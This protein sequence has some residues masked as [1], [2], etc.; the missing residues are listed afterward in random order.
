MVKLTEFFDTY[1]LRARLRPALLTLFPALA[2]AASLFPKTYE[3]M[4]AGLGSLAVTCGV[5][6]LFAQVARYLGRKKEMKLYERWGGIPTTVLLR[7]R[8]T[9][10]DPITKKRYHD[11]LVEHVSK[12]KLPTAKE[13]KKNPVNA[14]NCYRSAT[15]WLL[16][17]TRDRKR[18]PLVFE[19]NINYGFQR[20]TLALKPI[21]LVI[22]A[23]CISGTGLNIYMR[24]E[25]DPSVGY[26]SF[27]SLGVSFVALII[28]IAVVSSDWVRDA[29]DAYARALFASCD[30]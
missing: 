5:L 19:E 30:K 1:S 24:P 15:K 3:T 27:I 9:N 13:E 16:E 4:G 11:F 2:T 8:D 12:L 26:G 21:A 10:L 22:I 17:Y 28:W 23:L 7:H 6:V 25:F 29:S 20:N 14:D 18:F